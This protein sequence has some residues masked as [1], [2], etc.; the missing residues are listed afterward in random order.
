M[1]DG[2]SLFFPSTSM[3]VEESKRL[4]LGNFCFFHFSA[5]L[6]VVILFFLFHLGLFMF[7]VA[8]LVLFYKKLYTYFVDC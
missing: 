6:Y 8:K 4:A 1:A 5:I 7:S 2:R 3:L